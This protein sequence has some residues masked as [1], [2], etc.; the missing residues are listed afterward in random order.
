M[1]YPYQL[2]LRASRGVQERRE[3]GGE[4]VGG[5]FRDVVAGVNAVTLHVGGPVLPDGEWVTVEVFEVVAL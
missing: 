1:D 3:G 2:T 4:L 5:L